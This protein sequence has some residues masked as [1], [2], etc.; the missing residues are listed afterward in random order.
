MDISRNL[1]EQVNIRNSKAP[2]KVEILLGDDDY[3]IVI[4]SEALSDLVS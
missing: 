1:T 4:T 3:F 2:G